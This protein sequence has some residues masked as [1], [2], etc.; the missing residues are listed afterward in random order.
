MNGSRN[1]SYVK[2]GSKLKLYNRYLA[3]LTGRAI[4]KYLGKRAGE[5]L[6]DTDKHPGGRLIGGSEYYSSGSKIAP[7]D[8]TPT[9]NELIAKSAQ[10][11]QLATLTGRAIV[12]YDIQFKDEA[13]ERQGERND[14]TL[15]KHLPNVST[16]ENKVD[17][18]IGN[19]AAAASPQA[20][21]TNICVTLAPALLAWGSSY[22]GGDK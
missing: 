10:S 15:G 16:D 8:D 6:K 20:G 17:A 11:L 3:V 5:M 19:R 2:V 22:I 4:V 1:G 7:L 13:K 12:K 18:L 14:L 21:D 9:Y